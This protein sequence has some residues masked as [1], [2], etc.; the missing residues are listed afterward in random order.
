M[1]VYIPTHAR[2]HTHKHTRRL[3]LIY[4]HVYALFSGISYKVK[5]TTSNRDY[6]GTGAVVKIRFYGRNDDSGWERL[7][8]DFNKGQT[9]YHTVSETAYS[10]T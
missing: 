4:L 9:R 1:Y 3:I 10:V 5:T 8:G 2:A 7:S 6:A